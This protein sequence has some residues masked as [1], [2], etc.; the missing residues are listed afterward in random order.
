MRRL[1]IVSVSA[2]LVLVAGGC[3][4]VRDLRD[5]KQPKKLISIHA[6]VV[7]PQQG[8]VPL[9][10]EWRPGRYIYIGPRPL[11]TSADISRIEPFA[12]AGG[13]GLRCHLDAHGSLLWSRV[14]LEHRGQPLVLLIDG[15]FRSLLEV[16]GSGQA[17][18]LDLR[19]PFTEA[20]AEEIRQEAQR[21]YK[22]YSS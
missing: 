9:R 3:A 5:R 6:Y 14:S 16:H 22:R 11:L 15:K 12:V 18:A 1:P 17:P 7:R 13:L 21:N 19:G 8:A 20:E 4:A 10:A 2:A